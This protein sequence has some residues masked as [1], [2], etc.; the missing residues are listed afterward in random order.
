MR[1]GFEQVSRVHLGNC[2]TSAFAR[3]GSLVNSDA[4]KPSLWDIIVAFTIVGLTSVGGAAGPMRHVTVVQRHWLSESELAELYG[5]GQ[6]L[7]GSVVVNVATMMCD[8][9]A[10]PLG[11]LAAVAGLVIPSGIVAVALSGIATRLAASNPH[12]AGVEVGITGALAGVFI[13]NGLRV[14]AA[15]WSEAPDLRVAWRCAR[16]AIGALGIVLVIGLHFIVPVAMVVLVVLS[17]LLDW[18]LRGAESTA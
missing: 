10:G 13:S 9:F 12:F 16:V 14:L 5:L 4:P 8:R 1:I 17:I 15:L 2:P 18:H 6:A 11:P 3:V 7:P